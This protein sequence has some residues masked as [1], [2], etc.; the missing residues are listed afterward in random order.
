MYID[1]R[2][3]KVKIKKRCYFGTIYYE[4]LVNDKCP[5]VA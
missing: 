3:S 5:Q 2:N 4:Y 1:Y